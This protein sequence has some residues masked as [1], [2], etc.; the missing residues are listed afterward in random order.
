MDKWRGKVP[1]EGDVLVAATTVA[2]ADNAGNA[3]VSL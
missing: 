3:I 2:D 1:G